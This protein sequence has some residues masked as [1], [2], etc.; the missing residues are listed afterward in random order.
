MPPADS[1]VSIITP[2]FNAGRFIAE[3]IASVQAQTYDQW[4]MIVVD[5]GSRDNTCEVVEALAKEDGRIRLLRLTINSGPAIARDTALQAARGRYIAF[6]DSDDLWLPEKLD[7]QLNFMQRR[8][9]AFSY[10]QY[11]GISETGEACGRLIVVPPSLDYHQLLKNTAIA[12]LTVMIDREK[13]GPL[14]MINTNYDDYALWLHLLKKG[15]IAFGLQEDLARYRVV[16]KSLSRRKG[17]AA[18]WVWRIYRDTEKLSFSYAARC[19][20]N[21]AWRAYWKNKTL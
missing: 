6:L 10:T 4:E 21:Y 5:D 17:R 11:R 9:V 18:L 3:T 20:A 2:A 12:T 14:E 15:F 13:T 16:G 1:L 8:G 19:F 7:R